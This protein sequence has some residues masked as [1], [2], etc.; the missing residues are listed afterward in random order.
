MTDYETQQLFQIAKDRLDIIQVAEYF[1]L[2]PNRAGY[3]C[4]PFHNEKTG[5][6]H[7]DKYKGLFHCFGCGAGGDVITFAGKLWGI[8][9]PIDVLKRL[10]EAFALGLNLNRKQLTTAEKSKINAE[11]NEK[12]HKQDLQ[13]AFSKWVHHAFLIC[14]GYVKLL[15]EWRIIYAPEHEKQE[16][17]PLFI[18]S[19]LNLTRIEYLCE[20]LTFGDKAEQQEFYRLCRNE[21]KT[22]EQRIRECNRAKAC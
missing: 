12:Q 18:E 11:R 3:I 4:C 13:Q 22:I 6:L 15:R 19:L 10:N 2:Q 21:V 1:G 9:K 5:S 20:C 7:I 14:T 8:S 17:H 16:F